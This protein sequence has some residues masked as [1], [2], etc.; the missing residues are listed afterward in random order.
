MSV[1]RRLPATDIEAIVEKA[2][3]DKLADQAGIDR[4]VSAHL[5][6]ITERK[7]I[8]GELA[9]LAK[10]WSE[11]SASDKR[12]MICRLIRNVVISANNIR[13]VF[14]IDG[15]LLSGRG[16]QPKA[17][18]EQRDGLSSGISTDEENEV[19]AALSSDS[20]DISEVV[21]QASLR[22]VGM[23]MRHVIT[24]TELQKERKPDPS[25]VRTLAMAHRFKTKLM[26]SNGG[27]ISEIAEAC[28][29]TTSYFN[30]MVRLAFLSP[31]LTTDI[32]EGRQPIDLSS[33]KLTLRKDL[34]V[35]W[36]LQK[37]QLGFL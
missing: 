30:R 4:L 5:S 17:L 19:L 25:L 14:D 20:A 22:R 28:G 9:A 24:G 11:T 26:E 35:S 16:A 15:M 13:I 27:S 33:I 6:S 36:S 8:V 23:E 18:P 34:P 37:R 32:L 1:P 10:A 21:V 31:E 29:V 12:L 2:I 3:V 7:Q